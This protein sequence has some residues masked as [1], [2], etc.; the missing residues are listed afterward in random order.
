MKFSNKYVQFVIGYIAFSFSVLQGLSFLISNYGISPKILDFVLFALVIGFLSFII[1]RI[2]KSLP[3]ISNLKNINKLNFKTNYSYLNIALTVLVGVFFIYY[4]SA[5]KTKD[6]LIEIKLPEIISAYESNKLLFVYEE[7]ISLRNNNITNPIL[8]NYFQKVTTDVDIVSQPEGYDVYMDLLNDSVQNW[9]YLGKSPIYNVSVPNLRFDLKFKIDNDEYIQRSNYWVLNRGR[10][11][12]M[13]EKTDFDKEK[14]KLILGGKKTLQYPGLDHYPAIEIGPYLISKLEV[15]NKDFLEFVLNSGYKNPKYWEFAIKENPNFMLDTAINFVD[16]FGKP[17]PSNWSYG[18][19]PDGQENFPVTG[20]SWYEAMAYANYKEMSLPN[21]YQWAAAA[22]LSSSS[23]FMYNS[24]FSQNQLI[25]AGSSQNS[26]YYGLYDIAGNVREW[27][28]NSLSDDSSIKGILGGSFKDEPYYYNDYFGQSSMDRSI[29]NG[30]RLVKNLKSEYKSNENANDQYYVKVRDFLNEENVSDD[31]FEI[32]KSQFDYPKK[33]LNLVHENLDYGFSSLAVEKFT[34]DAAYD[35]EKLPGYVFYDKNFEKPYKPIIYFPGSGS[36]NTD[37]FESG[38][39]NR[40]KQYSYLLT[41]GYAIIHPI[42]KSTFERR[43]NIRSDY[44]DESDEYKKAVISWGKDYK[45]SID[46]IESR[47]DMDIDKLSYYG[48]S[49]GGSIANILLAIDNRVKNSVL[50]VAGL[51]F[52]TCKKEV[53][54]FY[55]TP[56]INIPVL[57][58]NGKF[59]HFF[60]LE[61]SQIPMFK[62]LGTKENDKKHFVYETGHYVPREILIKEHLEWLDKYDN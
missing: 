17:G 30:I 60:P 51:E 56:R 33:D 9:T 23:S 39:E 2:I 50:L 36:I 45:R 48:V 27:I 62:L 15:T 5:N 13:P 53:D 42:Y 37:S 47:E 32:F 28:V 22:T 18:L 31:V 10:V 34:I 52:Q 40:M 58:L 46:Y 3:K 19:Y 29:G 11:Y 8:D 12:G 4:Y 38:I 21:V 16:K 61:T 43:D 7:I 49:W 24:N 25:E 26:N 44:P 57:M 6:K 54:K 14:F 35:D 55:Y 20:I 59:D 1:F 41:E